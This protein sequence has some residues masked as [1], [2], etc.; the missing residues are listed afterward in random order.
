MKEKEVELLRHLRQNSRKSLAKISKETSI[1]T[2]TLF[3][4]LKKL[5]NTVITKHTSLLDYSKLG[6]NLK[7]NFAIKTNKKQELKQFL[8]QHKNTNS[9]SKLINGHDFYVECIFKDLKQ[10]IE[11]K[12]QL[13]RFDI[14][15]L[16]ETQI[17]EEIKKEGFN[18]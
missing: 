7:I 9:L 14:K 15:D 12:E 5:E 3:E 8:I 6:Y 18:V 17:I 2:S 1:P 10:V 4:L 11:F 16:K 13:E